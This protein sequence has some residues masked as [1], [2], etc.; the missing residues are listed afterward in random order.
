MRFTINNVSAMLA[1]LFVVFAGLVPENI[2]AT[3]EE[4]YG[5]TNTLQYPLRN[6][7][8]FQGAQGTGKLFAANSNNP[9][10]SLTPAKIASSI[11]QRAKP[12]KLHAD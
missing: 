6:R 12:S 2:I 1:V 10:S 3:P 7:G 11:R 4:S 9:I 8:L 5:L